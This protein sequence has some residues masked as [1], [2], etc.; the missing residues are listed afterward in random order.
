[1]KNWIPFLIALLAAAALFVWFGCRI[2][3]GNGEIAVLIRKTGKP[4]P[5]GE[6]IATSPDEQGIQ[7]NVLGE[8][9]YFRNPYVWDWEIF[10]VTDVPAGK[11]AVLVRR[12]GSNN[13][14]GSIIAANDK[15]RGVVKEVLGTGRH[16]INP[17]AYQVKLFDDI[18]I[19]PGTIGVV[20]SLTGNDLF[21]GTPNDCRN[22]N[23][24]L[25]DS[26]RKG[27]VKEVLKEGTHRINPF[28]YSVT[29]VN[30]RRQRHEFSGKDAITFLTMDGF[31]VSIEGTVEFNID[32]KLAP[33]LTQVVGDMEDI[34]NKI[35]LPSVLGFARIE[36]SK[37][38]A[39][40]FIVGESRRLFQD[41]LDAFLKA[42]CRKWGIEINSVLIRD[43]IAPQTVAGIIR[44]RELAH[45]EAVKYEQEI[46]RARSEAELARQ[47][48]LADQ[49]LK[50][51][52]AETEKL[53]ASISARQR[54][55]EAVV[56]AETELKVAEINLKTAKAN[57]QAAIKVAS[58]ERD[59]IAKRNTSEAEVLRRQVEAYGGGTAY[60]QSK[61]WGKLM[62]GIKQIITNGS[63]NGTFG[64]P[65]ISGK[66]VA[67]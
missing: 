52:A 59:I 53:T 61:L 14:D 6:I 42:N 4:L 15:C 13:P 40:E 50:K 37:K 57:A 55:S 16:R 64:L 2:E 34:L 48:M 46:I 35:I 43:I 9:R 7:L 39:T 41:K 44:N 63:Q 38:Q 49:N 30:I 67:K 33:R 60:V 18:K 11:F 56:A 62:P 66:G 12:S 51:V 24:F 10:P 36:G 20:T 25:V 65:E 58:A 23:G 3:P 8:G 22:E 47:K 1:M 32:E 17:Y 21:S 31:P 27:V 54:Q 19:M 28:I 29:V 26:G 5:Q 45:Q